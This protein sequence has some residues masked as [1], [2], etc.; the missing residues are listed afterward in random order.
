MYLISSLPHSG[1]VC[2]IV[3]SVCTSS[4]VNVCTAES[5]DRKADGNALGFDLVV[6]AFDEVS[7][8]EEAVSCDPRLTSA[9]DGDDEY[10]CFPSHKLDR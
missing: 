1:H 10:L 7:I 3:A 5:L 9:L 4:A 6:I 2:L 8:S